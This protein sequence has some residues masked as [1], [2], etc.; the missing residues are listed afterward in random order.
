MNER[1]WVVLFVRGLGLALLGVWGP[2]L[3]SNAILIAYAMQSA[4]STWMGSP[5]FV[6]QQLL[7]ATQDVAAIGIGL[8]LLLGRRWVIDRICQQVVGVC[9]MCGERTGGGPCP[10]CG[11]RMTGRAGGQAARATEGEHPDADTPA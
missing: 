6:E 11:H 7:V 10:E 9:P 3:I 5:G 4:Q 1:G 2:S 8:Y